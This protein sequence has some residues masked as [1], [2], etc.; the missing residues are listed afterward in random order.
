MYPALLKHQLTRPS[1]FHITR[2]ARASV[3]GKAQSGM[4][5]DDEFFVNTT[6][7]DDYEG[8]PLRPEDIQKKEAMKEQTAAEKMSTTAAH[9]ADIY[10]SIFPPKPNKAPKR[11]DSNKSPE[12]FE[13]EPGLDEM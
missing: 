10:E 8:S 9:K 11:K 12:N 13:Q 2:L 7:P 4:K 1:A 6:F 5:G 3:H